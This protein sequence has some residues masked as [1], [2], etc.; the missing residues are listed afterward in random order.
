MFILK[1]IKV[2]KFGRIQITDNMRKCQEIT[3]I[4]VNIQNI[5]CAIGAPRRKLDD[6]NAG[7]GRIPTILSAHMRSTIH[8]HCPYTVT[9]ISDVKRVK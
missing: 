1:A 4:N 3:Y 9:E 5:L 6:K 7:Q 8:H 2:N